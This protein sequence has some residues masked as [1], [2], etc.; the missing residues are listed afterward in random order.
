MSD[1]TKECQRRTMARGGAYP[2]TCPVC[3]LFG[4]CE[5]PDF[6]T[7]TDDLVGLLYT[8]KNERDGLGEKL[9]TLNAEI[10]AL[11]STLEQ[12]RRVGLFKAASK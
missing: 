1:V 9:N 3:G 8:K 4:P 11:E 12:V 5:D 2:K 6:R 7:A 10:A